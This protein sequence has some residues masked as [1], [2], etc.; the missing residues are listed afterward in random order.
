MNYFLIIVH[1]LNED[2][3]TIP[4][5]RVLV[6]ARILRLVGPPTPLVVHGQ[7]TTM[8]ASLQRVKNLASS[9]LMALQKR[10]L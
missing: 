5:R 10:F 7:C 9:K 8:D 1:L 6:K 2:H 4:A 3:V